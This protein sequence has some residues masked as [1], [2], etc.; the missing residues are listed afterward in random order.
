MRIFGWPVNFLAKLSAAHQLAYTEFFTGSFRSRSPNLFC[1]FFRSRLTKWIYMHILLN[2]LRIP[3]VTFS[4]FQLTPVSIK[5]ELASQQQIRFCPSICW[6]ISEYY[7]LYHS[8]QVR[9]DTINRTGDCF[10]SRVRATYFFGEGG[11]T[12]VGFSKKVEVGVHL[13]G[14]DTVHSFLLP[15]KC[16]RRE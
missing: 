13:V 14:Y 15:F 10:G 5:P 9:L 4:T 11:N 8:F 2:K 1:S 12:K 16:F 3:T 6:F 7:I